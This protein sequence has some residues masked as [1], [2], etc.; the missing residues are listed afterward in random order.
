MTYIGKSK[1]YDLLIKGLIEVLGK[2]YENYEYFR[3]SDLSLCSYEKLGLKRRR[4]YYYC[5]FNRNF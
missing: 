2:N 3:N 1:E 4:L 5:N